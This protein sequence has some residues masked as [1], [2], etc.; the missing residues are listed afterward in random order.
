MKKSRLIE[1][2]ILAVFFLCGCGANTAQTKSEPSM[3]TAQAGEKVQE[4]A[5]LN[6]ACDESLSSAAD[7]LSKGFDKAEVYV[8]FYTAAELD[9]ADFG[10]DEADV[11]IKAFDDTADEGATTAGDAQ[12]TRLCGNSLVL[13]TPS[14]SPGR[15]KKLDDLDSLAVT[16]MTMGNSETASGK[17]TESMLEN[18]GMYDSLKE[19][20]KVTY[21]SDE[22][23]VVTQIQQGVVDCGI[24]FMS[25]ARAKN[26]VLAEDLAGYAFS[27]VDYY[28]S[29]VKSGSDSTAQQYIDY[30]RSNA[31]GFTDLGFE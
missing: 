22:A 26:I 27:R 13:V 14:G 16:L 4:Y 23:S 24:I 31:Q 3:L 6:I 19:E 29:A 28:C 8:R 11:V 1:I 18:V 12:G 10:G 20:N 5:K 2:I 9:A 30:I 21:G 15:I 17:A 25:D 7:L